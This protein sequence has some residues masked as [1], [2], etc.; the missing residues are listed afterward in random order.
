MKQ[1]NHPL[2]IHYHWPKVIR[3]KFKP[4]YI[5]EP[6]ITGID[7]IFLIRFGADN[8]ISGYHYQVPIPI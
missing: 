1:V 3:R 5:E 4:V 6:I 8:V 7:R 2:L